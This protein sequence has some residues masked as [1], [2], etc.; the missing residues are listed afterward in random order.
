MLSKPTEAA[1]LEHF[2]KTT[3]P[4]GL[5]GPLEETLDSRLRMQTRKEHRNDLIALP[6]TY[7]WQITLFLWPM[8]LMIRN[9]KGFFISFGI[10]CISLLGMYIFWYRAL[11]AANYGE[12]DGS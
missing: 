11:P 1:V 6:F 3:R 5:W 9:W 12:C 7:G 10:F 2:Y 4:F 8:L